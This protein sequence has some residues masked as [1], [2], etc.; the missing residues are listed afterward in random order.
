MAESLGL[1]V[2]TRGVTDA[3]DTRSEGERASFPDIV[4]NA[5]IRGVHAGR[6]VPGQ[7]LVEAD[8]TR[9][10]G[11]S[12]GPVREALK[13]LA[14][15]G[16][17]TLNRHR[18]AFVRAMTRDEVRDTLMILEVLTGLVA[19]L[20]AQHID[21]KGNREAF[22]AEH[23]KLMTFRDQG[24]SIAFLDQRRSYYDTLLRIGGSGELKRLMPLMQIHLLRLQFQPYVTIR[25]REKQFQEYEAI[26]RAVLSGNSRLSERVMHL[27]IRRTRLA[28]DRL[29]QEAFA[30]VQ[31]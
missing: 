30:P 18:G 27:H 22:A 17:V 8:L 28:L 12:R 1:I 2:P 7:R 9:N 14:A 23:E 3:V 26:S 20:A 24:D 25:Q 16:V 6:L 4:V 19:R 29:S 11:V 15:E 21:L 5:I 31:S 10:L 13:R